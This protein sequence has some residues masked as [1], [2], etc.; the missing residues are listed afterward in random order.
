M[1][2]RIT[3]LWALSLLWCLSAMAQQQ[4]P[5]P[6]PL[7]LWYDYTVRPGKEDDFMTLVKTVGE[8]VRNKLMAEGVI[9]AWGIDVPILRSPGG[10]THTIWVSVNDWDAVGKVQKA[11]AD[12]LAALAAE[13]AK[14]AR[15]PAMT[16]AQRAQETFDQAKTRDWLTRDLV[17]SV[18]EKP[19]K[20][21]LPFTRFNLIKVKPG[22]GEEYRKLW[23]KYNKPVFDKALADGVI[24]GFGL[25]VEEMRT[26]GTFTH[27]VWVAFANMGDWDK[28][29]AAFMADR[30]G[31]SEEQRAAINAA[32]GDLV[33]GDASRQYATRALMFK[34]PA[35]K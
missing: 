34:L 9:H 21:L 32:F 8:P 24:V 29:R 4:A 19:P 11:M 13:E 23:E 3:M 17:F 22:K 25:G 16:T 2:K 1:F 28:V 10:S 18:N 31:R 12:R 15:K 14:A 6:Q 26:E 27:F 33:E 35:P 30:A 5:Q 7:T 20:D